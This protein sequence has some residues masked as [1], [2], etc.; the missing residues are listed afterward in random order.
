MA[1]QRINN[2]QLYYEL[3]GDGDDTIV[4]VHGGWTDHHSWQFVVPV[5][6]ER[7]RVLTYD[8]RGHSRSDRP[9]TRG[10]RRVDEDDLAALVETLDLGAV[11][12]VGNSYGGSI[13]LGLAARRPDLVIDVAAH[14]PPLLGVVQPGTPL[15]ALVV[16][17]WSAVAEVERLLH[18]GD[19]E[20]G[21]RHFMEH[22]ALGPGSWQMLPDETRRTFS[23]N[24]ATFLDLLADPH[25]GDVPAPSTTPVLLTD[26]GDASPA[27]LPAI[28][29]ELAAHAYRHAARHT[30]PGAGHAPHLSEPQSYAARLHSF[31]SANTAVGRR[32]W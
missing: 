15:A 4:L 14:E 3:T 7:Y 12:L 21:A 27:W 19:L 26:G 1:R 18:D 10:S 11:H 29:N 17:V 24:A 31:L 23:A 5:L 28:V 13:A 8:R 22:I 16:N 25:W 9:T 2:V 30:F 32:S 6:A 20:G